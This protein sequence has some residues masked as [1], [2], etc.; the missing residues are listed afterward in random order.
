MP[1]TEDCK[2]AGEA[3][4]GAA[5]TAYRAT[6][7][8]FDDGK[9]KT[10]K[11]VEATMGTLHVRPGVEKNKG[12]PHIPVTS[13]G[14][15]LK[16][17]L[18]A[19]R[20]L[21]ASPTSDDAK[22]EE[23]SRSH[24]EAPTTNELQRAS[25]VKNGDTSTTLT[26]PRRSSNLLV[27]KIDDVSSPAQS[28]ATRVFKCSAAQILCVVVLAFL[29]SYNS[30]N[31]MWTEGTVPLYLAAIWTVLGIAV[32]LILRPIIV[33]D[34]VNV[35]GEIA[36]SGHMKDEA[37]AEPRL[38]TTGIT[39]AE[40]IS[41]P[42]SHGQASNTPFT[43]SMSSAARRMKHTFLATFRDAGEFFVGGSETITK[44]FA[45]STVPRPADLWTTLG[46]T[47]G[48]VKAGW[49]E[50]VND[51]PASELM[52]RLLAYKDFRTKP[53][54]SIKSKNKRTV[55]ASVDDGF[56]ANGYGTFE[57][58]E[59]DEAAKSKS[60]AKALG[61]VDTGNTR[62]SVLQADIEVDP[63]FK[64]RGMDIFRSDIPEERIWRQ[65]IL[66]RLVTLECQAL[67]Y[68]SF[69]SPFNSF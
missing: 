19:D 2:N 3:L 27:G 59:I 55:V 25:S 39:Q 11:L 37:A 50:H 65:P 64:L 14:E 62:A 8:A 46:G 30:R 32:G 20:A 52:E 18:S 45:S 54:A 38:S 16:K 9:G 21:P 6:K 57:K 26:P 43:S 68:L 28:R 40:S 15:K 60:S 22:E 44:P 35:A 17:P 56:P 13:I 47:A 34:A 66:E 33:K 7:A 51:S 23:S 48:R 4:T 29:A 36:T 10:E 63:L 12:K 53:C 61:Q 42:Q 69:I 1:S 5:D 67:S 31:T 41:I 49:E 24:H 58:T